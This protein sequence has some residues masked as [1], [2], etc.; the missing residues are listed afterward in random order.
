MDMVV[1]E[2]ATVSNP[3][4]FWEN[5]A[6]VL[7]DEVVIMEAQAVGMDW[8]D[9]AEGRRRLVATRSL[10]VKTAWVNGWLSPDEARLFQESQAPVALE[11]AR[12][13]IERAEQRSLEQ[14]EVEAH[15]GPGADAAAAATP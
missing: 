10:L 4:E 11:A 12:P 1:A 2:Y 15:T 7:T 14:A 8:P 3:D 5:L 13:W 6:A 9:L